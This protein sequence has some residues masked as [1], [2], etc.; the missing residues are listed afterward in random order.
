MPTPALKLVLLP[1]MDGTGELFKRFVDVL[2][3]GV[4]AKIVRYPGDAC[5]SYAELETFVE[6]A[7]P[8]EEPFV[9]LAES[10]STPVAIRCAA[11]NPANLKGL[12]IC[13]GF[14]SSPIRGWR[15]SAA[16]LLGAI[17]LRFPLPK[18]AAR[19]FIV[20]KDTTLPLLAAVRTAVSSVK[21]NVLAARLSE[22]LACDAR[23]E[24]GR[25]AVPILY[26]QAENDRLISDQPLA[27]IRRI[28]PQTAVAIVPAPHLILQREPG[29]CAE[30][31]TE[32]ISRLG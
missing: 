23:A 30:I 24:L 3:E 5:L 21:P 31:V 17:L 2:P 10:Y 4:E 16:S 18:I 29:C 19:Y 12:V 11:K 15:R 32:F 22:I 7:I 28:Q 9:L 8:A 14:V 25:V 27:E 26:I 20:G 13:A 1:G 6:A